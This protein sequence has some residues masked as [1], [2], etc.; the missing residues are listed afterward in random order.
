MKTLRSICLYCLRGTLL[1]YLI[2]CLVQLLFCLLLPVGSEEWLI[3]IDF[4][5]NFYRALIAGFSAFVLLVINVF[6]VAKLL[7]KNK[8]VENKPRKKK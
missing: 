4:S 6:L 2:L 7:N 8:T 1:I 3:N 5:G